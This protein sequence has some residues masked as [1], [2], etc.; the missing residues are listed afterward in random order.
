VK[1]LVK[2]VLVEQIRDGMKMICRSRNTGKKKKKVV[3]LLDAKTKA[4]TRRNCRALKNFTREVKEIELCE[5]CDFE[6]L[7]EKT[8]EA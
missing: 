5:K 1:E 8:T 3:Y 6:E 7:E 2:L 4:H